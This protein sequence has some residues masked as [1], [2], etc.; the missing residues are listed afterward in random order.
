M[1]LL[2]T[3]GV[4]TLWGKVK[5]H[6]KTS[7]DSQQFKTINGTSVKGAG[8]INI[9]LTLYKVVLSL[10]TSDIDTT[11]IYL[12]KDSSV[13]DNLYS[14]YMY[15]DN[16]WEKLGSFRSSVDLEPYA[17]K[18]ETLSNL[19]WQQR[20]SDLFLSVTMGDGTKTSEAMPT[21]SSS[22]TGAMSNTDKVKLDGIE[23]S[24]NNY[25][26]PLASTDT[27]GGIKVS[28]NAN[29]TGWPICVDGNGLAE[30]KILGLIKEGIALSGV[31]LN[32]GDNT[33]YYN[34]N[35]IN[36]ENKASKTRTDISFPIKSGT[37]ALKSDI[38]DISNLCSINH[39]SD[40]SKCK[41][42]YINIIET[43]YES[44]SANGLP[45]GAV[46]FFKNYAECNITYNGRIR[47]G[48]SYFDESVK[49]KSGMC[50]LYREDDILVILTF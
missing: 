14:E 42:G 41:K 5:D 37:L 39:I 3:A 34:Y 1:K 2:D 45:S 22:T 21:A 46:V 8:D 27:R 49:L 23:A 16:K 36:I 43:T 26:L 33:T 6:V 4:S 32:I 17:K 47:V 50:L 44:F 12:L 40:V 20:G 13:D 24:A 28:E 10:P 48:T 7:I 15:V 35:S 29:G 38:P 19:I 25:S 11:K 31:M 18:S 9:D 30:T